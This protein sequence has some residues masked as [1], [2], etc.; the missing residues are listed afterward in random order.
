MIVSP[1]AGELRMSTTSVN[2]TEVV[3]SYGPV[4]GQFLEELYGL[5]ERKSRQNRC[6]F[7]LIAE[8]KLDIWQMTVLW[9]K[10]IL[11][12]LYAHTNIY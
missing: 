3:F 1:L 11:Q 5:S 2:F 10:G 7:E 12:T 4:L 8:R 6:L 9:W